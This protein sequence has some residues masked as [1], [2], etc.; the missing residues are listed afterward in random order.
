[1]TFIVRILI[2]EDREDDYVLIKRTLGQSIHET[3]IKW[4]KTRSE[5]VE[6]LQHNSWDVILSDFDLGTFTGLDAFNLLKQTRKDVPF[7]LISGAIGEEYAVNAMR[8]GV[9]DY[10][11]KGDLTRLNPALERELEDAIIR[12]EQVVSEN[13]F[14]ESQLELTQIFNSVGPMSVISL[15]YKFKMVNDSFCNFYGYNRDE[16]MKLDYFTIMKVPFDED[17]GCPIKEVLKTKNTVDRE[18]TFISRTNE[19]FHC[20]LSYSPFIDSRNTIIGC[21]VTITDVSQIRSLENQLLQSQKMEALGR[22]AGGIA[23]DFNNIMTVILGFSQM[24]SSSLSDSDSNKEYIDEILG[25]ANRA[26][27]LTEQILSFSRKKKLTEQSIDLIQF[28]QDLEKILQRMIGEDI[29]LNTVFSCDSAPIFA[30]PTQIEQVILNLATNARDAMPEGGKFTLKIDI[31]DFS[32]ENK[33]NHFKLP[34]QKYIH[35]QASDTGCGIKNELKN[36]IFEP[37]FTTK[38]RGKGTGLGLSTVYGIIKQVKGV[39]D[40]FSEESMGTTF[41]IYIPYSLKKISSNPTK[42]VYRD[43]LNGNESI[44]L[45]EDESSV[46]NFTKKILEKHGYEVT[47]AENGIEAL[48]IIEDL[49][50]PFDLILSDIIMPKMGGMKLFEKLAIEKKNGLKFLFMS[51]YDLKTSFLADQRINEKFFLQKPFTS[52]E[53][54]VK[55]RKILDN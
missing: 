3:V 41:H 54:L 51:G 26:G 39:I 2:L 22:F 30:N 31:I 16:I 34:P 53:L 25:A 29:E 10:I 36:R 45:V 46:Q 18:Y 28:I 27:A 21:V 14:Q 32:I 38:E 49:K 37:F 50:N 40:V 43:Q 9:S 42:L 8:A 24:I 20:L 33:K 23:H 55:M 4:V 47:S 12:K 35:L 13:K 44:L 19:I 48:K 11:L 7:I 52:H 5:F 6:A 17:N 1:M 15:D